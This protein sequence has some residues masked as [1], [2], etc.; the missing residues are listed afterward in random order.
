MKFFSFLKKPKTLVLI[1][2]LS[3]IAI[4][5]C[6]IFQQ[7]FCIPVTWS[8]VVFTTCITISILNPL[9][10]KIKRISPLLGFINGFSTFVFLYCILFMEWL[11]Y[12]GILLILLMGIGLLVYVPHC[13]LFQIIWFNVIRPSYKQIT[14]WYYISIATSL[15]TISSIVYNYQVALGDID[16]MIASNYT[17]LKTGYFTERIL[18]AH[19][20]YHTRICEYD[21]WRPPL[22]DPAFV[23]GLWSTWHNDPLDL[24]LKERLNLYKKF[25]PY[26]KTKLE[27]SCA[28]DYSNHYHTSELWEYKR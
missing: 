9:L 6:N 24:P 16:N 8:M 15:I 10:V 1:N 18:G 28:I 11:N 2:L 14:K 3:A 4:V 19:F 12:A 22:H 17:T 26:N 5:V 23:I 7:A 25:Y 20:K 21:G 13:F 27:C